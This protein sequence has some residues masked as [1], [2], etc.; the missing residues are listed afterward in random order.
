MWYHIVPERFRNSNP[1]NDPLKQEIVG[2]DGKDW[3]V[4]PWAS[5][6]FKPQIWEANRKLS[7]DDL[8]AQRRFGGDL[9]GVMEKLPY[10]KELG[11]NVIYLAP[12]FESRSIL[13]YNASTF[14]HIDDNFGVRRGGGWP[15]LAS[16]PNPGE[17]KKKPD[18][19]D[20]KEAISL[21]E[22]LRAE[23]EDPKTWVLSSSDEV[24]LA[25][26]ESA[27]KEGMKVVISSVFDYCGKDFWA[28]RNLREKQMESPYKDWFE[29]LS[30]DDPATPDTVE[31]DYKCWQDDRGLPL[32]RK[33]EGGFAEPVQKYILDCTR[34]WLDPN[35]DGN[36]ADGI[37]GWFIAEA[38]TLDEPFVEQ[39]V[40]L[41]KSINP[42][43]VTICDGDDLSSPIAADFDLTFTDNFTRVVQK[44]F[45][46]QEPSLNDFSDQL[47]GLRKENTA[48]PLSQLHRLSDYR[49]DRIGT[50][51]RNQV[52]SDSTNGESHDILAYD[53]RKPDSKQR[54]VQR[55]MV[56]FQLTYPGAPVTYYG[57]EN[58]MWGGARRDVVKP[59]LWREFVYEKETYST[60]LPD[61]N[62]ESEN[63]VDMILIQLYLQLQKI[64]S[65]NPALQKGDFK[66]VHL[67]DETDVFG[68]TRQFEKNE[69]LVVFNNG[70]KRR[71]VEI[72]DLW[73]DDTKFKDGIKD[74]KYRV[75]NGKVKVDLEKKT[76]TI[77]IKQK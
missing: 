46:Q 23:T 1:Y 33:T 73:K 63:A 66:M 30:W 57:D 68:F 26:V 69:V 44:Y 20:E 55:A 16:G 56:F 37:D 41:M 65:E 3:Q 29:V 15:R 74:E 53:P 10:L 61:S 28:F 40:K 34:R 71:S 21:E 47:D 62:D 51:V 7:F 75:E 60:I 31:F 24:F 27:H 13:K 38:Q 11:V 54:E 32:F 48:N 14:H 36:P 52:H 2:K 43:V 6:W 12:I 67:D 70:D 49:V 22:K 17:A 18:E 39:W 77:L 45:V 9:R 5:D 19:K 4:H 59:M 42:N 8:V 25:L 50:I 35:G 58:G 72:G 64:R 76:G